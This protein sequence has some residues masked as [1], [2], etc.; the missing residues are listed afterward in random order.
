MLLGAVAGSGLT[1]AV[2]GKVSALDMVCGAV[3]LLGLGIVV[4]N[5]LRNKAVYYLGPSLLC[6][7]EAIEFWMR[8]GK[9]LDA[10]FFTILA[11]VF[12]HSAWAEYG[13]QRKKRSEDI[14]IPA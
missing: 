3:C 4:A 10:V 7:G 8:N 14:P 6:V 1:L 11:L 12:A 2:L 5:G 13:K 9:L